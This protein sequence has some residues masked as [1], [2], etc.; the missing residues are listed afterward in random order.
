MNIEIP[1]EHHSR[2]LRKKFAHFR[3]Q[4][5]NPSKFDAPGLY[6]F[7]IKM[8]S[9]PSFKNIHDL[10]SS[11]ALAMNTNPLNPLRCRVRISPD[12]FQHAG[13]VLQQFRS[14]GYRSP[15]EIRPTTSP[16]YKQHADNEFLTEKIIRLNVQASFEY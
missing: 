1:H 3:I 4:F 14:L 10:S 9:G 7:P 2:Y 16:G 5:C 11:D 15:Y 12:C 8:V 13:L 6:Q